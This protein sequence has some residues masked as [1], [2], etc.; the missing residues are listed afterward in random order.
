VCRHLVPIGRLGQPEEVAEA[1]TFLLSPRAA[2]IT[3]QDIGVDGG[4]V[5]SLPMASTV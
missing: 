1:V 5:S 4:L 3:G 2:Y